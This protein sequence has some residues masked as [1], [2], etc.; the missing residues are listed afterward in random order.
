MKLYGG[1]GYCKKVNKWENF[2]HCDSCQQADSYLVF[3]YLGYVE[4]FKGQ[5]QL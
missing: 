2:F 3:G 5:A 4:I 1:G